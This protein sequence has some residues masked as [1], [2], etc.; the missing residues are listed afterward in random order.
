MKKDD[1]IE[2]IANMM[3]AV[4]GSTYETF[5]EGVNQ[6]LEGGMDWKRCQSILFKWAKKGYIDFGVSVRGGW[7]TDEGIQKAQKILGKHG[8]AAV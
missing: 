8:A 2:L 7:F 3:S 5:I 6:T 4:D 1:E